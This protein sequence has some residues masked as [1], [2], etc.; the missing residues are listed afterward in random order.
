MGSE[1][2]WTGH[3]AAG[4]QAD[5][6]LH[7]VYR[8]TW[9][10]MHSDPI[11]AQRMRAAALTVAACARAQT[12]GLAAGWLAAPT[13]MALGELDCCAHLGRRTGLLGD[14]DLRRM[15]ALLEEVWRALAPAVP[16]LAA[17][18]EPHRNGGGR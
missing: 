2:V 1:G 16:E 12:R 10:F 17:A 8:A 4:G 9:K 18:G 7:V 14:A 11:L 5:D 13:A 15:G 6:L 3:P